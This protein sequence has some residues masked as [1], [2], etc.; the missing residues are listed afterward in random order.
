MAY[1]LDQE[2]TIND[3]VKEKIRDLHQLLHDKKNVISDRQL[4]IV[5]RE[6]KQYQELLYQNRVNRQI[7]LR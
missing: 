5:T 7:D 4:E 3:L 6:L 2:I 1:S